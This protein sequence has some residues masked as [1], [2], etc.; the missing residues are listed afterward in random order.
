MVQ[1]FKDRIAPISW[2]L[3]LATLFSFR[4]RGPPITEED[5]VFKSFLLG[6]AILNTG[7]LNYHYQF[8]NQSRMK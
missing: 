8:E 7:S 6:S 2:Q 1:H 5:S 4:T 3:L